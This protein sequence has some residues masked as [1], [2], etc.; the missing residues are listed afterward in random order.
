MTRCYGTQGLRTVETDVTERPNSSVRKYSGQTRS[1][2]WCPEVF[3][4]PTTDGANSVQNV[5][6]E[7]QGENCKNADSRRIVQTP[8]LTGSLQKLKI[9]IPKKFKN[10]GNVTFV[11]TFV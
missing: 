6:G 11:R 10:V 3:S 1:P 4:I 5:Q 9:P 8:T 2:Y 7:S